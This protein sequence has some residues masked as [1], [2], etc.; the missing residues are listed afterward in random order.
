M[1]SILIEK[2]GSFE[3]SEIKILKETSNFDK[4]ILELTIAAQTNEAKTQSAHFYSR[5]KLIFN[6]KLLYLISK[7]HE[8]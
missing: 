2:P 4:T 3:I 1:R 5:I 6:E 8:F 7:M